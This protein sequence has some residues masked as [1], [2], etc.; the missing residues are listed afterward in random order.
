MRAMIA[1]LI[2][3]RRIGVERSSIRS[4]LLDEDAARTGGAARE[5]FPSRALHHCPSGVV[6]S[7]AGGGVNLNVD[8]GSGARV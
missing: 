2:N 6:M 3:S 5:I 8:G 7:V 1:I 4:L